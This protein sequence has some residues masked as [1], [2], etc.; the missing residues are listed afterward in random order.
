[1]IGVQSLKPVPQIA[2]VIPVY[3]ENRFVVSL[4]HRIEA[5]LKPARYIVID[6]ASSDDTRSLLDSLVPMLGDRLYVFSNKTN[7]GHGP[8]LIKGLT[9]ALDQDVD[10]I[11]TLDGDGNFRIEDVKNLL[12]HFANSAADVAEGIRLNRKNPWFRVCGSAATNFLV[13]LRSHKKVQDANTPYRIYSRDSL[14]DYLNRLP[15]KKIPTPNLYFSVF[16]RTKNHKISFVG[17]RT[18]T[19]NIE[20]PL[21]VSWNQRHQSIPSLRF[22]KFCLK[23]TYSWLIHKGDLL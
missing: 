19:N 7:E 16:S 8:T 18:Q 15:S 9:Y 13:Q 5:H 6:D 14:R 11:M 17:I 2:V 20:Q 23:S 10:A 4:I 1:M 12:D 21:G 22:I 3:N